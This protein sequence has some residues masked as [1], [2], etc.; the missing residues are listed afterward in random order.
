MYTICTRLYTCIFDYI[1]VHVDA[2]DMTIT[3]Y[4]LINTI[5]FYMYQCMY[6]YMQNIIY[7]ILTN[8]ML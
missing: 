4:I 1:L 2:S 3:P 5:I 8:I 6:V 7:I